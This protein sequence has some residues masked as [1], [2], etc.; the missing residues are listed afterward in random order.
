MI[1]W[2]LDQIQQILVLFVIESFPEELCSSVLV[3]WA[4]LGLALTVSDLESRFLRQL[5]TTFNQIHYE[6]KCIVTTAVSCLSYM[7]TVSI[8]F[9]ANLLAGLLCLPILLSQV[10]LILFAISQLSIK[11]TALFSKLSD[12]IYDLFPGPAWV[13]YAFISLHGDSLCL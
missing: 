10:D 8:F 9:F 3:N 7:L 12:R 11:L 6:F 4:S 5:P 1:S 2:V 13:C